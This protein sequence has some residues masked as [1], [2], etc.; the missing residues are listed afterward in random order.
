MSLIITQTQMAG[1]S[2]AQKQKT[3]ASHNSCCQEEDPHS[4]LDIQVGLQHVSDQDADSLSMPLLSS[5]VQTQALLSV[6]GPNV[7][8]Q[9]QQLGDHSCMAPQA[10]PHEHV[11]A[12][13]ALVLN[14]QPQ[15]DQQ[16]Y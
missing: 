15:T 8:A 12:I 4:G 3:S 6:P 16:L 1:Q 11:P 9:R 10:S 7:T 14:G 2:K 5:P 13:P